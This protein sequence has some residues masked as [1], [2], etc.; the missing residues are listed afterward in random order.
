MP[1]KYNKILVI[2]A[3]SGIGLAYAERVI[4]DRKKVIITG[5]RKE[6]LDE[7]VSKYGSDK[8]DAI[9][10]DVTKLQ[11]IP[12]F[13]DDVTAKHPDLDCVIINSGIQRGFNF[14]KPETVDLSVLE[15]EVMTNYI[16]YIHLTKYF[17]AFMQKQ[18][19]ETALV[20]TS[21]GLALVPLMSRPNYS[22][23]KAALHHFILS[24]REQL[25]D[26]PGNVKVFE[27]FPPA[28]QTE[29]HDAKHQP[30]IP[31]GRQMGMPLDE[32]TED[33]WSK[34]AK[35]EEQIPVGFVEGFFEKFE[36][37]RQ[38]AFEGMVKMV[39]ERGH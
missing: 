8:A 30:D 27:I 14:A 21:S 18:D 3:T 1:I 9:A 35:G 19:K 20:Y 5:R 11:E 26:G 13:V 36:I 29:L 12:K 10:F 7:F 15:L 24:L 17:T 33:S 2:G 4:Q 16:S 23:T 25:R 38:K 31:N 37:P 6:N 22:A 32:F 34:F 39:R 28:V